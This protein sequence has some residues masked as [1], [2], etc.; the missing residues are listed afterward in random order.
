MLGDAVTRMRVLVCL[1]V[2]CL[3]R[4]CLAAVDYGLS[5]REEK[6]FCVLVTWLLHMASCIRCIDP[7]RR[8]PYQLTYH[9]V[10]GS[11]MCLVGEE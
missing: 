1:S 4:I 2:A 9:K 10:A 7:T 8:Y 5:W 11:S 6:K 3:I